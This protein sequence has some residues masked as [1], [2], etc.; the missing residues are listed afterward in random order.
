MDS[1]V[2]LEVDADSAFEPTGFNC[3][4]NASGIAIL[5][6]P[7][8]PSRIMSGKMFANRKKSRFFICHPPDTFWPAWQHCLDVERVDGFN[9]SRLWLRKYQDL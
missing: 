3:L 7:L 4:V 9:Y 2:H 8:K 1:I 5:M 6:L